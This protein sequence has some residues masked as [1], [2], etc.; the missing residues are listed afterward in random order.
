MD[1]EGSS[2]T[3]GRTDFPACLFS[4]FLAER[5]H[6][7]ALWHRGLQQLGMLSLLCR[8]PGSALLAA[9]LSNAPPLEPCQLLA[10]LL[11]QEAPENPLCSSCSS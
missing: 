5:L 4:L 7:S 11:L 8:C 1:C 9:V 3:S 2:E 10:H 6:S